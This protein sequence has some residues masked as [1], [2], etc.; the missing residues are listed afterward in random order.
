MNRIILAV[1]TVM[2]L[3][4]AAFSLYP[5]PTIVTRAEW[6]ARAPICS[7]SQCAAWEHATI[8]HTAASSDYTVTD[9]SQCDDRV[10][11]HQ[12]YHI[13]TNGWCDIGYNFLICKHGSIFEGR[14]GSIASFPRGAHDTINCP[15]LGISCMG[16]FHTPYDHVPTA[17]LLNALTDLIAWQWDSLGRSPYGTGTYGGVTDNIIGGHRDV[18]ATAC[19]G[20]ILYAYIGTDPNGGQVRTDVCTK[21]DTCSGTPPAAPSSLTATAVSTSQINLAW[22]DNSSDET[23]F[24]LERKTGSGS[25]SVIATLAANTTTYSNTGLTKNTSYTYQ[26]KAVKDS[27]SSAYSNTATAKTLRK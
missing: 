2:L 10:R 11:A 24:V 23:G 12:N 16:Y 15:G 21:M 6:S 1:L 3:P 7:I 25:F 4:V 17:E 8:H 5:Q 20:D 19:P 14:E 27:V 9:H 22:Q 26:V 18:S 13:D